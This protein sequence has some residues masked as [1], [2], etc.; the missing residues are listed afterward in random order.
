MGYVK[1]WTTALAVL[2]IAACS[3]PE[4]PPK[5]NVFDPLT[6]QID[7]ARDVQKTVDENAEHVRKA[8]DNQER[9]EPTP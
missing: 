7:R 1:C 2:F 3:S 6:Q 9:G 4:P 5:K 8:I